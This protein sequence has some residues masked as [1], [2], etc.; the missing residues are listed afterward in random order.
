MRPSVFFDSATLV[1]TFISEGGCGDV[2]GG[3]RPYSG[4]GVL[5]S[6]EDRREVLGRIGGALFDRDED[7]GG[8]LN[9]TI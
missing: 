2:A 1:H 7:I 9:M 3:M 5:L 6:A 8:Q 4:T